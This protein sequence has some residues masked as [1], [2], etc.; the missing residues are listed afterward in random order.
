GPA[1]GS[2]QSL[3][4]DLA[5]GNWFVAP[6]TPGGYRPPAPGG[7]AAAG[8]TPTSAAPAPPG[9]P[10][11]PTPAAAAG[12]PPGAAPAPAPPAAGAAPSE[13]PARPESLRA[14]GV[15]ALTIDAPAGGSTVRGTIPAAGW[16]AAASG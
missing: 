13:R 3:Q 6:E 1:P 15:V 8:P 7:S 5:T 4:R 12:S 9:A 16:A 10:P 14:R 11:S 2:S